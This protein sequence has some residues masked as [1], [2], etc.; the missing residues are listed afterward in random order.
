MP[1]YIYFKLTRIQIVSYHEMVPALLNILSLTVQ[2]D[3]SILVVKSHV[4]FDVNQSRDFRW[5]NN[6]PITIS[7]WLFFHNNI[8]LV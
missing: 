8:L 6:N 4:D 3:I 2:N 1:L 7:M 5:I